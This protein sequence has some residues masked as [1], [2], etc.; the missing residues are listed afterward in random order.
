LTLSGLSTNRLNE[1]QRDLGHSDH[2][3]F[4]HQGIVCLSSEHCPDLMSTVPNFIDCAP[5]HLKDYRSVMSIESF[6]YQIS[7]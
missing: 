5:I 2:P 3:S 4:S 7:L 1:C 6:L